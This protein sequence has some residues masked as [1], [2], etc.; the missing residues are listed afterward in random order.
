MKKLLTMT[1]CLLAAVALFISCDKQT[2]EP[3]PAPT[4]TTST[5]STPPQPQPQPTPGEPTPEPTPAPKETSYLVGKVFKWIEDESVPE[6][7]RIYSTLSFMADGK[8]TSLY[9]DRSSDYKIKYEFTY[10][11]TA[12]K[13][14]IT[15]GQDISGDAPAKGAL[16]DMKQEYTVDEGANTLLDLT[17]DLTYKLVK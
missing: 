7:E 13:L 10:S 15:F 12:P 5:P 17:Q 3:L 9:E 14:T 16:T 11:Y 1:G 2:P 8:G 6:G 4:P